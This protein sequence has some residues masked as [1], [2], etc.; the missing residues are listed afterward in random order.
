MFVC[1]KAGQFLLENPYKE[2]MLRRVREDK[3]KP[4]KL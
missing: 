2:L 1:G 3:V 4:K